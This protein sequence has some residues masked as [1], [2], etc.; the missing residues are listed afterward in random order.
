MPHAA[1][2]A[3]AFHILILASLLLSVAAQSCINFGTS[4]GSGCLCPPGFGGSNCAQ[5]GCGGTIFD[6]SSRSL[7]PP[8]SASGGFPNLTSSGCSCSDGWTGVGC[9]VCTSSSTCQSAYSAVSGNASASAGLASTSGIN[10]TMV[11]NTSPMVWAAGELS[12]QVNNPTLQAIY[13]LQ[14]T[15]NILRTLNAS[16]SPLHNTSGTTLSP[17]GSSAVYAQLFYAG[18]EQFSCTASP[19]TQSSTN[20]TDTWTCSNLKCNCIP[21]T[22]FCGGVP[23]TNLTSTVDTL[24]GS[25]TIACDNTNT[26]HF[27]QQVLDGLFGSSGL[28][29]QGCVFGECVSQAVIDSTNGTTSST[30]S[31]GSAPLS[32]GVIAGL[33]V[34]G[35]LIAIGLVGIAWGWILQRSARKQPFDGGQGGGVN[36]HWSDVSYFVRPPGNFNR[37]IFSRRSSDGERTILDSVSGRVPAGELM[38][39]LGPSGAGKTTLVELIAGKAKSGVFTGS[40]TFPPLA[41]G[42]RPRVAFVPQ[43]D[44][45]PAVLTVREALTF[46]ASLRLPESLSTVKKAALVS[47]VIS[48]LGLDDVAETRIGATDGTGR[49]ISGGEARRVS[50]G[51]ELVGCPD[52]LVCDEPTSGLD[53]VSAWRVVSVLKEVARGG[54]GLFGAVEGDKSGRGVAIICSVHQP[55]SRLYHSFDSVLL[56]SHGRALYSG[57]GG[58]APARHFTAIRD[59]DTTQASD[60]PPYEEGYNVADYLLEIAS[61]APVGLFSSSSRISEARVAEEKGAGAPTP[62]S[63]EPVGVADVEALI[64]PNRNMAREYAATF[65][66]QFQVLCG[67]EWKILRRDK[68][69]F[70]THVV[71]STILGAFCG[72]LYFHT[73]TTIAGFQS[74][75]GCLFFLGSLIAFSSLSALYNIVEVRPL[76]VRERSNSYYSPTAWLLSR[77][78]FDVIPLRILPTIIVSTM[79]YWMAGLAHDAAHFF[80]FLF[81]LVLFTLIMTLFNFLLATLFRNGGIAILISALTAL[82]QM[83]YAGFFVHLDSIPPVLRWLQWLC[84]L[85]FTLEALAV[86][87]VGSGL[88][89]QDTL[90]GVPVNVS[91]TLI[92]QL[93]FGFGLNNYYRDVLVSFAFI[94]GFGVLV[95]GVVW[96]KVREKR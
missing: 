38:A 96:L 69:L 91:A 82:Y 44:V 23:V 11:C 45:L 17:D 58:L 83:T 80:K 75:V 71:L 59:A 18:V 41:N 85:K 61:A 12:C 19:C 15:L 92:M 26:C 78:F 31:G 53:S 50:I 28:A 20:T 86:N 57:P 8:S 5:P 33:A 95:I 51:L 21:N 32:G 42:Q 4:D 29:M 68:T 35:S 10:D 16:L 72:G 54:G 74:R 88:M 9:N 60:V 40:I 93:L 3:R 66:T 62:T 37:S 65:L 64:A 81:I 30:Q 77:F 34:V 24:G 7:A 76:F 6:G 49:G 39:I 56:L 36:V 70:F 79:T 67:R 14:S 87:E 63:E 43:T 90:Q 2:I 46:A 94:A 47:A 25:L 84:P 55:S 13:P 27:Q 22:S 73:G 1:I 48:K 52:V 89:I